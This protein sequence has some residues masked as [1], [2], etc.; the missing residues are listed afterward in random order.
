MTLPE[1]LD[2]LA[3]AGEALARLREAIEDGDRVFAGIF[4]DELEEILDRL[5][6]TL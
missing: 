2:L 4:A 5:R 1:S 3:E 6:G